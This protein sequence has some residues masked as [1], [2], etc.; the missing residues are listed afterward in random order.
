MNVCYVVC[1]CVCFYLF[2]YFFIFV[3]AVV[4]VYK[5]LSNV[6]LGVIIV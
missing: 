5:N 2:I 6:S 3:G 1:V 4:S